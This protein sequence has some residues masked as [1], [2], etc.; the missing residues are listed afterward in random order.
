[1]TELPQVQKKQYLLVVD[2]IGMAMLGKL[3]P[4]FGF[5]PVEGM[6]LQ[7]NGTHQALV[8][9]IQPAIQPLEPMPPPASWT[10]EQSV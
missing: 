5:V 1:M 4:F 9:P 6:P 2:E 10:E 7:G 3:C 8:T